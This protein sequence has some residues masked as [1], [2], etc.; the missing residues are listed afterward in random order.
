MYIIS[1]EEFGKSQKRN[2][3]E[4][5]WIHNNKKCIDQKSNQNWREHDKL[6]KIIATPTTEGKD[7]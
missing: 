4:N 1:E 5:V 7:P 2:Y 3:K 6:E